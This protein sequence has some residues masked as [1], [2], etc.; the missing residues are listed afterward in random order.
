MSEGGWHFSG[1]S[2]EIPFAAAGTVTL[3]FRGALMLWGVDKFI[4]LF[5]KE[6]VKSFLNAAA[7]KSF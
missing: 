2:L 6:C 1:C 7:D 4:C 3:T 5:I